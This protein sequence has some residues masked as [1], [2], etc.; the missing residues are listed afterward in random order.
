MQLRGIES[1]DSDA[2]TYT[3]T[4]KMIVAGVHDTSITLN[5]VTY[6]SAIT[7]VLSGMNNRYGSV[8]GGEVLELYGTGF[9]AS[10]TTKVTIDGRDCAVSATTTT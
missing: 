10:A 2:N 4:P 8:L 3:C 6:D 9:S 1:I 5:D 7:P